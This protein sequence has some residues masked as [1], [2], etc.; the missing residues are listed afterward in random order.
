MSSST[1]NMGSHSLT[2]YKRLLRSYVWRYRGV[3]LLGVA[4]MIVVA[5]TTAA[6]A[7]LMKPVL[8]E[9]FVK[10]NADLLVI[11]PLVIMALA[12]ANGIGD[13]GQ[14]L[15]LKYVGQKVVSDM[16]VELFGKLMQADLSTFHDQSTGR[17]I[18]R[19]TNDITLMRQ[20]VSQVIT[21]MV[22]ESLS[23]LFLIGV[24]F[25]QSLTSLS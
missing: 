17:L 9:I 22:K 23:M 12:I 7:Y 14:S 16:Q 20:S 24:M 5:S 6:N 15:S 13:Y 18:S 2:L 10:R 19:L 11:L 21:G 8:D 1:S 25:Y 3:L 4:C